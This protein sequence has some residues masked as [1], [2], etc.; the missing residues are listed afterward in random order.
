MIRMAKK[1][2]AAD[3]VVVGGSATGV[4]AAICA[5]RKN[6]KVIL[7]EK[8]SY[9][10]GLAV[11][12]L[13]GQLTGCGLND[14]AMFGGA[15]KE[16][17]DELF[18]NNGAKYY[19]MPARTKEG[20]IMLL[21]YNVESLGYL[22]EQ[23]AVE[24]GVTV[25]YS[26]TVVSAEEDEGSC[27][28]VARGLFDTLEIE[29]SLI[30]DATGNASVAHLMGLETVTPDIDERMSV[31]LIFKMGNVDCEKLDE[32][33]WV[34][35][36]DSWHEEGILPSKFLAFAPCPNTNEAIINATYRANVDQESTEEV[37]QALMELRKQIHDII[38]RF[39]KHVPGLEHSFLSATA[40]MLGVRDARRIKGQ[41]CLT[42]ED[43]MKME[44][45][46]DAVA[47]GCWPIDVHL[48]DGGNVWFETDKP[49]A[50]PY[51]TMV[52][53][54]GGRLLVTGRGIDTD[55]SAFSAIRVIP[56]CMGLG[57]AAGEAAVLAISAS[58]T[59][60]Q[61]DG[62]ELHAVL[63]SKGVQV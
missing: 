27:H 19:P 3:L 18:H 53:Q 31:A 46:E 43:I 23:K 60:D 41:F 36:R 15:A 56:T 8:E 26:C 20:N 48:P 21:R 22:L 52:P 45:Y 33:D 42:G 9:L 51:W 1:S 13:M 25:L 17:I 30:I 63:R 10:G 4:L 38:P 50:I 24:A 7:I 57:E 47:P 62:K 61:I 35:V 58:K 11:G 39:I 5:A 44:A 16:I 12:S 28:V 2:Y 32:F 29:S 37:T 49:Y 59:F 14:R 34:S 6:K 54:N 40:P 55:E